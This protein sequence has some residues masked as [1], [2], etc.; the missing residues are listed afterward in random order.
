MDHFSMFN[1]VKRSNR[2]CANVP[3]HFMVAI[4]LH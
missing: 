4:A 1:F 3:C 2:G